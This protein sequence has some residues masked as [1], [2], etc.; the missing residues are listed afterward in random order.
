MENSINNYYVKS[1]EFAS[2]NYVVSLAQHPRACLHGLQLSWPSQNRYKSSITK[3]PLFSRIHLGSD[4][5]HVTLQLYNLK[6]QSEDF[7]LPYVFI[8]LIQLSQIFIMWGHPKKDMT[9]QSEEV[10]RTDQKLFLF[11]FWLTIIW[12]G[13]RLLFLT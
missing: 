12:N 1:K 10:K 13:Q 7:K 11:H 4:H 6:Y 8:Y 2:D 9:F 5:K 3:T